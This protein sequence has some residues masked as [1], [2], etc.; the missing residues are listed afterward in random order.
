[1][2]KITLSTSSRVTAYFKGLC[3]QKTSPKTLL[4]RTIRL[5]KAAPRS[6]HDLH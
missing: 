2:S 3:Q 5:D 6:L 4:K 1:M